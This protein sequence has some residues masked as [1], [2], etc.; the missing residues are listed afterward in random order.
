MARLSETV[1]SFLAVNIS[2]T[3]YMLLP[4]KKEAEIQNIERVSS[5]HFNTSIRIRAKSI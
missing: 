4:C 3:L 1:M 5:A 2:H